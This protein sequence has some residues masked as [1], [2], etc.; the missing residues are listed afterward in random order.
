[1]Q[2]LGAVLKMA[3][4]LFPGKSIQY[5]SNPSLCPNH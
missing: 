5:H 4:C 1:M 2:Y 3:E